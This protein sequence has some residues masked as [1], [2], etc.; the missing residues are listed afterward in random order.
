VNNGIA[1]NLIGRLAIAGFP[2]ILPVVTY[3]VYGQDA[4]LNVA[5]AFNLTSYV[6]IFALSGFALPTRDFRVSKASVDETA[7]NIRAYSRL[8]LVQ[9][10]MAICA[11]LFIW[12][13]TRW[14][15]DEL[16][17]RDEFALLFLALGVVQIATIGASAPTGFFIANDR[18][19]L[20]NV[21][22]AFCRALA[23]AVLLVGGYWGSGLEAAATVWILL[24]CCF[25]ILIWREALGSGEVRAFDFGS[26]E[27]WARFFS[28]LRRS[29][30]Y[31]YWGILATAFLAVPL[32][33]IGSRWPS[34]FG[35]MNYAF[36]FGSSAAAIATAALVPKVNAIQDLAGEESVLSALLASSFRLGLMVFVASGACF[37]FTWPLHSLILGQEN[38][39]AFRYA[40]PLV[41]L[42]TSIRLATWACTQCAIAIR[43]ERLVVLGPLVEASLAIPLVWLLSNMLGPIGVP[44]GLVLAATGRILFM[45]AIEVPRL[46]AAWTRYRLGTGVPRGRDL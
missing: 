18:H 7:A 9:I 13:M 32:T 45:A 8:A 40:A 33:Y 10:A 25:L 28:I 21:A 15:S 37:L 27:D 41:F 17:S 19:M 12:S 4:M 35:G 11:L 2:L 36:I 43:A 14:F 6:A 30:V 1:Y 34:Q 3:W 39:V 24:F 29:G 5:H 23:I 46:S 22:A 38:V 26:S 44:A 20:P 16:S 42:T 31:V